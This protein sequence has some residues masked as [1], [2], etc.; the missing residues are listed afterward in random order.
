MTSALASI[1]ESLFGPRS[2]DPPV[3]E[4]PALI[5]I[6]LDSG[7][8]ISD[9]IFSPGRPPQVERHGDLV[10]VSVPEISLLKPEDTAR[11]ASDLVG[12]NEHAL[13]TL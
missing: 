13:R 11:I 4:T 6:M 8:G 7:K 10:G 12:G 9:L 5:G 1:N 3:I 2:T